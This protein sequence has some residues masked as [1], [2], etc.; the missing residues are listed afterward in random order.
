MAYPHFPPPFFENIFH[1]FE[2]IEAHF[3][4]VSICVY[5]KFGSMK[6]KEKLVFNQYIFQAVKTYLG[7]L[8]A[9]DI[10]T[11]SEEVFGPKNHTPKHP[12]EHL[13]VFNYAVLKNSMHHTP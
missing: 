13:M 5:Q 12:L 2:A 10:Q 3:G 6:R 11:P 7:S 9:L 1:F 8:V 4:C